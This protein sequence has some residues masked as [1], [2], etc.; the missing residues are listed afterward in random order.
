MVDFWK[1]G[2]NDARLIHGGDGRRRTGTGGQRTPDPNRAFIQVRQKLRTDDSAKS[3]KARQNQRAH[4]DANS[5]GSVF[6]GPGR[7]M[8]VAI[9]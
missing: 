8:A 1:R 9:S 5:Y 4:R 3:E 6:N 7:G 2:E